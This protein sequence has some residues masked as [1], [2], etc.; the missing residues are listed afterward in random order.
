MLKMTSFVSGAHPAA[1]LAH[2]FALAI[3]GVSPAEWAEND[4]ETHHFA[5]LLCDEVS[6]E[7]DQATTA[8]L[9]LDLLLEGTQI[10]ESLVRVAGYY[11]ATLARNG[12]PS[13]ALALRDAALARVPAD[14]A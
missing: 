11:C 3:D 2:A 5:E 10:N 8:D 14:A 13:L 7:A 1:V 12:N 4:P 6:V 9:L